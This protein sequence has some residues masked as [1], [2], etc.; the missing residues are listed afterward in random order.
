VGLPIWCSSIDRQLPHVDD[1][2]ALVQVLRAVRNNFHWLIKGKVTDYCL[3]R[4]FKMCREV[5]YWRLFF[6]K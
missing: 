3:D 4:L 1:V 2:E 5:K 6:P